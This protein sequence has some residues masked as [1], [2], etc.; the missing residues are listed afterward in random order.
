M[1]LRGDPGGIAHLKAMH[2]ENK[3]YVKFLVGEARSNT[4][5]TAPFVD[6]E[7]TKYVLRVDPGTGSLV[8]EL[9]PTG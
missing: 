9:G 6:K 7:G 3:E 8:V 5:L 2:Q 1:Q 4:D